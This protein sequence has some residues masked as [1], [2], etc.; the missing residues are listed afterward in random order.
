[1][2]C[3][4]I[5][6]L[7]I[8]SVL[9]LV[10]NPSVRAE[11]LLDVYRLTLINDARFRAARSE[12]LAAR[13]VLPQARGAY[14]PNIS[15]TYDRIETDQEIIRSDN[16]VFGQGKSS[17]PTDNYA[18]NVTQPIFR[19]DSF[20]QIKQARASVKEALAKYTA[21]E[22]ELM[23]RVVSAYLGVLA[24]NDSLVFSRAESKAVK[25]Q[26]DS[27]QKRLEVG[28]GTLTDLHETKARFASVRARV[29]EAENGLDDAFEALRE[30]TGY[31]TLALAPLK[32]AITLRAPQPMRIDRWMRQAAAGNLSLQAQRQAVEVARHEIK[33]QRGGHYPSLD[34]VGSTGRRDSGGSLFGGGS[35]VDTTDVILRLNVPLYAGG[36]VASRVTEARHRFQQSVEE[37]EVQERLVRRQTRSA[38]LGVISGISKSGAL[39][40]AV[41]SQKLAL[42]AKRKGFMTGAN[43]NLAVLDAERDL[44]LARRDYAR[45]RYDYLIST[46]RLKQA[47][48]ILRPADL[49]AINAM[50]Y[51]QGNLVS[52]PT[53][54][55]IPSDPTGVSSSTAYS[56]LPPITLSEPELTPATKP[57]A[58]PRSQSPSSSSLLG[59]AHAGD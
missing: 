31:A 11:D 26:L 18:L 7:C 9:M 56:D 33:R 52:L 4:K 23:L 13:E 14:L 34:L 29:L 30:N 41:V 2:S 19:Y 21:A 15:I 37:L 8:A 1:M 51:T 32:D 25:R 45:A 36:Q 12:Y 49:G 17:F 47:A 54:P 38:Y 50:L 5:R 28:L 24:A 59:P 42:R 27:A 44:H 10:V 39:S 35:E 43:S 58:S 22:Q 20:M 16:E 40:E 6:V 3:V 48:G 55:A 53:Q 46:I 57:K